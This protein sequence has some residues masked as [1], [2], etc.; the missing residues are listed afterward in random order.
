MSLYIFMFVTCHSLELLVNGKTHTTEN[1]FI[2]EL[3]K[4]SYK[5]LI[6]YSLFTDDGVRLVLS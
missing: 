2:E 3:M 5:S 1:F 4:L 6:I